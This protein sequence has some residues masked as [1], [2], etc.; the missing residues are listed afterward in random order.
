MSVLTTVKKSSSWKACSVAGP[1]AI[2]VLL[3]G[4]H[5]S[6]LQAPN[7]TGCPN[8][9]ACS[10]QSAK[11]VGVPLSYT[12]PMRTENVSAHAVLLSEDGRL[13]E[14]PLGVVPIVAKNLS[15]LQVGRTVLFRRCSKLEICIPK[16]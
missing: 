14:E 9:A 15:G 10:W 6:D 1:I 12:K 8:A 13:I 2:A 11:V 5:V 16:S 4:C 3:G 7:D